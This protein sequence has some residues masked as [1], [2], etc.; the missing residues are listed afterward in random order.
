MEDTIRN[1]GDPRKLRKATWEECTREE[2]VQP[3]AHWGFEWEEGKEP[4]Y[5]IPNIENKI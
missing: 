1:V 3:S 5:F 4:G 2:L